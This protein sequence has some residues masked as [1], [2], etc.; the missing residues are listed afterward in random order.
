MKKYI[1]SYRDEFSTVV[2]ANNPDEALNKAIKNCAHI[3]WDCV[4]DLWPEYFS[5]SR[6]HLSEDELDELGF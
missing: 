1:V 6:D 3:E 4:G 5:H 2:E